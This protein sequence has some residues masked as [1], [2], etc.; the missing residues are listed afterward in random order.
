[1]DGPPA[2]TNPFD[3][4]PPSSIEAERCLLASMML[5]RGVI[6]DALAA[7]GRDD[8]YQSDHQIIFDALAGLYAA[9][10]Q[11][12]AL[13]VREELI[14]RGLFEECGGMAYL[15]KILDSVPSS[16]HAPQY[17][18][19]VRQK[20]IWRGLIAAA[21]DALRDGYAAQD[22]DAAE[23]VGRTMARLAKLM[24]T[25]KSL[26]Y[27]SL[28]DAVAAAYEQIGAG[29][30]PLI[31]TGFRDLDAIVGGIAPGEMLVIGARPSMGKS[32]LGRQFAVRIARTGY[33]VGIIS[34]EESIPKMAR[35]L[36]SS[37]ASVENQRLRRGELVEHDWRELAGGVARLSAMPVFMADR[38][39]R[40]AA[41]RAVVSRWVERHGV[42]LV[43]LDYL[44]RVQAGGKDRFEKVTNASLE[45][46]AM[47]KELGV[48]GVVMSQLKRETDRRNTRPGMSDLRESGQIEQDA[49]GIALLHREDYYRATDPARASEP[50]DGVAELIIAKWRDAARGKTV[51]LKSNLRYQ[52]FEDF[53]EAIEDPFQDGR[54]AA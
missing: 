49:D 7:I 17:A 32:T 15:A 19:I 54:T 29:E 34:L 20:S 46:S 4:L 18:G 50:M 41:I 22:E 45:I 42:R 47:L 53:E 13:V 37:E 21:N 11:I 36:L 9:D 12:D 28:A 27:T 30:V 43:I 8:F 23:A 38:A 51:K 26:G 2:M 25:G 40:P 33:P 35:N 39:F 1:M 5:D 24:G 6:P 31:P 3:R 16:A 52:R 44:Q 14:R 48:A 10:A